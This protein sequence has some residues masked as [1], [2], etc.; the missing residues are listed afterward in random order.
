MEQIPLVGPHNAPPPRTL[1]VMLPFFFLNI[2]PWW[3]CFHLCWK[4]EER[5]PKKPQENSQNFF[6]NAKNSSSFY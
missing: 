5:G 2:F 4:E 6:S 3:V 1:N